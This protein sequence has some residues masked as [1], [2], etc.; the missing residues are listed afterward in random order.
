MLKKDT[1]HSLRQ[2][3]GQD[4]LD[5]LNALD[6]A[7]INKKIAESTE[8]IQEAKTERDNNPNYQKIMEDKKAFDQGF[9]DL[10]KRQNAIIRYC[11]QLRTE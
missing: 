11:L 7:S 10:K 5:E 3:L 6:Q 4:T 2:L 1:D 8:S 9:N